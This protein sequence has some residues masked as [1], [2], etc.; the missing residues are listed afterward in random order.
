MVPFSF[1]SVDLCALP[2][3]G[4]FHPATAS[5]LLADLHLEKASS[6]A[7]CGQ[8]LP[9]YDS[10]ETLRRVAALAG[11][12]GARAL[13]CLGDSFHDR[14]GPGRL[15][16]EARGLLGELTA[17][18]R[19]T[20]IV[21]NHDR[22]FD[23]PLGGH[24]VAEAELAGLWLRHEADP[25]DPRPEISGHYHPKYKVTLRGR[26]VSRPCFVAGRSKLILPSFGVLTGGMDAA[27][28]AILRA[29]GRDARALIAIREKL[30]GFPLAA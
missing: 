11:R 21:G 8:M 9:P 29:V 4:L 14:G 28:P 24:V 15:G 19:W 30:L 10:I 5:L 7:A 23:D 27:D 22:A 16:E 18:L 2:E 26:R 6:Y 1:C 13:Y 25:S 12:T 3:G 20:W 17:R